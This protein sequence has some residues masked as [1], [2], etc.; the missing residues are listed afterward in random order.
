M[1]VYGERLRFIANTR[2][3]RQIV[4]WIHCD[5]GVYIAQAIFSLRAFIKGA[6]YCNQS[7][8][9]QTKLDVR[10]TFLLSRSTTRGMSQCVLFD[11]RPVASLPCCFLGAGLFWYTQSKVYPT[12][13][14]HGRAE[15]LAR[16]WPCPCSDDRGADIVWEWCTMGRLGRKAYRRAALRVVV[17]PG[18]VV[19]P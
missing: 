17:S 18:L 19:S 15:R 14:P 11:P 12:Q 5:I 3:C 13:Q 9:I 4:A 10:P 7:P 6:R 8:I 1:F 16:H 2:Y